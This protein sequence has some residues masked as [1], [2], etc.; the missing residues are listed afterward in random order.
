MS[1]FPGPSPLS[2]PQ[3]LC[4]LYAQRSAL[5]LTPLLPSVLQEFFLQRSLP[6]LQSL[7]LPPGLSVRQALA[8]VLRLP[9]VASKRYLTNKVLPAPC[10]TPLALCTP[11]SARPPQERLRGST[12][13]GEGSGQRPGPLLPT[14]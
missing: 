9:A 1:P 10:S 7:T 3:V 13:E 11:P 14:P 5:V 2:T 6:L 12:R 8:R 4:H